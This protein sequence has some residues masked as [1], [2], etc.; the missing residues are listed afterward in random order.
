MACIKNELCFL[1][2]VTS[3]V[4]IVFAASNAATEAASVSVTKFDPIMGVSIR[5]ADR[6]SVC[7]IKNHKSEKLY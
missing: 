4:K 3:L 1:P 2:D 7:K 5:D 6:T